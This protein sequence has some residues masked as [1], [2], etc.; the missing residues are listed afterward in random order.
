MESESQFNET[1]D[2]GR[3]FDKIFLINLPSR[4][5]QLHFVTSR[6]A[7]YGI[8]F[9]IVSAIQLDNGARGLF[10]TM[11]NLFAHCVFEKYKRI[12]CLE[13][14]IRFVRDPNFFLPIMMHQLNRLDPQWHL[15][16]LGANTHEPL[17]Q[18]TPN[19][20]KAKKCRT[21]HA[22]AYSAA[23][24][25]LCLQNMNFFKFPID[26]LWQD[27]IQPLGRSYCSF[28]L[29]ATQGDGFS[30]IEGKRVSNRHIEERFAENTK[31]LAHAEKEK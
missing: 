5:I 16:Y 27:M 11:K 17:R 7:G 1:M 10:E 14:D 2:W 25:K 30:D 28:P 19:I 21:T 6:L 18:V 4:T 20:L 31:H 13:D 29:L 12:L 26:V 15:F 22:V 8:P 3:E 24:I 23:G 9:E